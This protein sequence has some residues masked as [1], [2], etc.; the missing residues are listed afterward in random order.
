MRIPFYILIFVLA[1]ELVHGSIAEVA[2]FKD[3]QIE[4]ILGWRH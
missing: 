2:K 4:F 3:Y 1:A